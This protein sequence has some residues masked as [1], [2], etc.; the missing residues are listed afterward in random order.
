MF[1]IFMV[2][3]GLEFRSIEAATKES[4][5]NNLLN[6]ADDFVSNG[7]FFENIES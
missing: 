5:A 6:Q 2:K 1:F 7:R 4:S 3:L